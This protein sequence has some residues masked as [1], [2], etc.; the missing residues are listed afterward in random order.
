VV[1][2]LVG[3]VGG[4]LIA[5]VVPPVTEVRRAGVDRRVSIVTVIGGPEAVFVLVRGAGD[6]LAMLADL[7][8]IRTDDVLT[9]ISLDAGAPIADPPLGADDVDAGIVR[10]PAEVIDADPP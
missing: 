8:L 1:R 3:A 10:S 6:A 7:T 9:E 4:R 5:V 2:A